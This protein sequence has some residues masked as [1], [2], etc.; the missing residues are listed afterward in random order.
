MNHS[1]TLLSNSIFSF[2]RVDILN[3]GFDYKELFIIFPINLLIYFLIQI[4]YLP[5]NSMLPLRVE[6]EAWM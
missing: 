4:L 5:P 3:L 2:L 6:R 1:I